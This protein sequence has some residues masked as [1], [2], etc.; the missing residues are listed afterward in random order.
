MLP[1][2]SPAELRVRAP[3]LIAGLVLFGLGLAFMVVAD[4]GLS[5]W[6]VLHQG[7]SER[8]GIPIGTVGIIAGLIVL[9][10]WIPLQERPGLG[11]LANVVL[12]GV[13]MDLTIWQF[14]EVT[15][16][17]ERWFLM[18]SGLLMISIGSG[19]Y[20][21]VGMGPGPRD[22]LMT[23]LARRGYNLALAR[24]VIEV[25]V[26]VVGWLLGGTVGIGTVAFS[27]GVGPL[28]GFFLPRMTLDPVPAP[29][30]G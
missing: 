5:P 25:L 8:S 24:T 27:F 28:V 14:P 18:V 30:T 19:L 9:G 15:N 20:I 21:G 12:I 23:G 26:L 1:T 6:E 4:L 13:V 17:M 10:A 16:L 22:G 29:A 3:R 11:T 2:P 7:L